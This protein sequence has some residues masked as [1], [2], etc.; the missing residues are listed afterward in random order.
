MKAILQRVDHASVEVDGE[1][2]GQIGSGL[3]VLLG[4]AKGD[5]EAEAA[6]LVEKTCNLRVFEDERG[7]FDRSILDIHGEL[8]I[9]S[10]FTILAD[11][12]KGR[13]PGFDDAAPPKEAERLYNH[14][15]DLTRASG[16][17][18]ATGRFQA[19]MLVNIANQGPV[20]IILDRPPKDLPDSFK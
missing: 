9:V 19:R 15:V 16:L 12:R 17:R 20:T 14:F 3:V 18:V 8:L 6:Y 1:V 2:V 5:T 10:Q 13:R 4:V 7:R 11:C